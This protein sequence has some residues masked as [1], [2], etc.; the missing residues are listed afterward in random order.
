MK[1]PDKIANEVRD[2][3]VANLTEYK[4]AIEAGLPAPWNPWFRPW[5]F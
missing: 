5:N 3:V 2:S 4:K 1:V